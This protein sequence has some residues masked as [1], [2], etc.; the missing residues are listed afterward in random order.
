MDIISENHL[1]GTDAWKITNPAVNQEIEGFASATSV[2]HGEN[3]AFY[4][5]TKASIF[6]MDIFRMGWYQGH[7]G[8][9]MTSIDRLVG[10]SHDPLFTEDGCGNARNAAGILIKRQMIE[11]LWDPPSYILRVPDSWTSGV[12]LA[13][14]KNDQGYERYI[15][16]VVRDDQSKSDLLFQCSVN[17][18][19][20]Y[21]EWGGKNLYSG[22]S[23]ETHTC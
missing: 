15:I 11:C 18:Y 10:K 16:F 13:K 6:R 4:V 1:P 7:W 22:N 5:N 23:W 12:Y 2:H 8:R 20:A 3:I 21:N 14:L 17:T 9:L 19:Q